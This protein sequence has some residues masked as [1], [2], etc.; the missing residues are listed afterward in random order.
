MNKEDNT[1][2]ASPETEETTTEAETSE[3][4]TSQ[5]D[6][7]YK[8]ELENAKATLERKEKQL[9]QA[10][11]VIEELK[12]SKGGSAMDV[13]EVAQLI[14]E[15]FESFTQQVRGDAIDS[16]VSAYSKSDEEKELI[17]HHLK[18]S[19]KPSGDD[20]ADILNA[21]ALANKT[22]IIQQ[23]S[24]VKRADMKSDPTKAVV[25]G[26]KTSAKSPRRL[27]KEDQTV[28]KAFGLTPEE[29]EKGYQR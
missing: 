17:K 29:L 6:V 4:E 14:D 12:K 16:L 24:E 8:A 1:Q 20:E 19:I 23:V 26:D 5:S 15:K 11:H 22:K 13:N 28:A 21:K 3:E 27:S 9:G 10:E 25:A 18:H 2:V 7:D